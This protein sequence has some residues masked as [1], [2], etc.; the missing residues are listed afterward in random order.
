M[1]WKM[2]KALLL[3]AFTACAGSAAAESCDR[4]CLKALVDHYLKALVAHDPSA[5]PL[6]RAVKFTENTATIPVGDGLW[7][8][9][10]EP[11]TTFAVYVLD[12]VAG[13]AG[14]YGAM[15]ELGAP[16][17]LALRL[18]VENREVTEIEHVVAR[19]LDERAQAN[20]AAP[21]PGLVQPVPPAER[22]S[23]QE[24]LRIADSYFDSI[25]HNDGAMAPFADDCAR[26]ENGNQT[27][28]K[29]EPN[30]AEFGASEGEQLRLAMARI[31]ARGCRDQMSSGILGYITRIRPRRPLIVDEEMGLVFAFPMFVHRGDVQATKIVGVPGVDTVSRPIGPFNL[32]AGEIFKIRGGRIH[33]IEANGVVLPYGS[34]SGWEEGLSSEPRR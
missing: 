31:D 18:R 13:Q 9:A 29:K 8:N 14:F 28:T 16:V 7:V 26:H 6:A 19:R 1:G 5:L 20:L 12:P 32:Q 17:I 23:R 3:V 2:M 4:S 21:R 27:T 24:Q 33:E 30:P 22:V 11:S 10:S 15:K 25:E 34:H